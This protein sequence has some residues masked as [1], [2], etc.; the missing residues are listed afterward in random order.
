MSE[1]TVWD[2][3]KGFMG[4][5]VINTIVGIHMLIPDSIL[6]GSLLLYFLTQNIAFGVFAVFVF[7][8]ELIHK[9]IYMKIL[10]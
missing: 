8:T 5:T 2:K 7:E 4:G 3:F 1:S 6:F 10:Y 9:L